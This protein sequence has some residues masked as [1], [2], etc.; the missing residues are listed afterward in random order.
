M[1][2]RDIADIV[3]NVIIVILCTFGNCLI[4]ISLKKFEWLRVVTNYFVALL[5]FYDLCN[6]LSTSSLMV[7]RLL[8]SPPGD[9]IT[10]EFEVICK[11][12]VHVAAFAGYGNLLCVIII[13]VDRYIYIHWPLRYHELVTHRKALMV[14]VIC[15]LLTS[16]VSVI[17]ADGQDVVKPCL[18]VKMFRFDVIVSVVIPTIFLAF[19]LVI[20]LYG[21]IAWLTYKAKISMAN[22]LTASDQSGS[23]KRVT[24]VISLVVGVFMATYLMFFVGFF[25][26]LQVNNV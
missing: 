9:K 15:L 17:V 3:V 14:S 1:Y 13:T 11:M 10:S 7:V 8:I 25:I 5:A 24:Q 2:P 16:V 20:L 4:I 12:N 18:A 22:Q 19:S 6:G 26:N 23:Q 21:K